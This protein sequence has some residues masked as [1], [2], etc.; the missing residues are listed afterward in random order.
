[1][2]PKAKST[3]LPQ[4][5]DLK[6]AE[7]VEVV[8]EDTVLVAVFGAPRV[9]GQEAERADL[10][11]VGYL[12]QVGDKVLLADAAGGAVVVGV[13]GAAR[14][15]GVLRLSETDEG[16]ELKI[17]GALTL[18]ATTVTL[19]GQEQ[20]ALEAPQVEVSAGRYEVAVKRLVERADDAYRH[21]EGLC[22]V[23]AGR[24]RTLVENENDL[25]AKRTSITSSDDTVV[26]GKRVLLG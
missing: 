4:N 16:Q 5:A 3:T 19:R 11:V 2:K 24:A 21:V 13:L 23:Q 26:D 14:R 20:V 8:D 1:M 25:V 18:T 17:E 12:P 15:R 9:A 22:E 7:V 10:A 6:R